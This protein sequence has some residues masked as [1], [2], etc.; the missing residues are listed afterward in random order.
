MKSLAMSFYNK[1]NQL[2]PGK[3]KL[4]INFYVGSYSKTVEKVIIT[5]SILHNFKSLIK[6]VYEKNCTQKFKKKMDKIMYFRVD[7]NKRQEK[8]LTLKEVKHIGF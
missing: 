8:L 3:E 6:E 7:L 5:T 1:Y 2:M 4:M